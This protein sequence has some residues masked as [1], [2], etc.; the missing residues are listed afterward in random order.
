MVSP[1]AVHHPQAAH[2]VIELFGG[3]NNLTDYV[4]EDMAEMAA[5]IGEDVAVL[6]V[7]D[8]FNGPARVV[9]I[10]ARH[11]VSVVE[12][13]GEID[14]GDPEVL[15]E[16]LGRALASF[17]ETSRIAIGFW[18]HGSGVFDERGLLRRV[19][20]RARLPRWRLSRSFPARRLFFSTAELLHDV[21]LRA[22]L[23]DDQSGGLLT[24]REAGNMLRDSFAAAGRKRPVDLIFS[25]TCLNGM[26]EVASEFEEF[27]QCIVGSEE[28][29][30][31]DGW[32]YHEWFSRMAA[33]PPADGQAWGRQAVEAME[34]GYAGRPEQHPVTL[35]A[36]RSRSGVADAFADLIRVAS[37]L[38]RP[39]F[40]YLDWARSQSQIFASGY[41][42]YD[43]LDFAEKLAADGEIAEIAAAAE[44]LAGAIREA[45]VH[46]IALGAAVAR[47]KGLA[48]W[49]PASRGSFDKDVET[50]A[51]LRFDGLTGWSTY[52]DG[53]R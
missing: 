40:R 7:A 22:M 30:P 51:D 31:G 18:D 46:S 23:H 45:V 19:L 33:S 15:S 32:D 17:S 3:D 50:Y 26:I 13:L 5:G 47:A 35:S 8:V 39:G 14:T 10:T 27:A 37:P 53:H 28:L 21:E 1:F 24:N 4:E 29:E 2:V 6:A 20:P 34:A 41:D 52:L 11:G 12:E 43:M 9:E 42:S 44:G 36:V 38:G 25:D 48:F 16:L 49:F